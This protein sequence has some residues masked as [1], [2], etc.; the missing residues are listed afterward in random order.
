MP[1]IVVRK[2]QPDVAEAGGAED[3]VSNRMQQHV[4]V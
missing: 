3:R 2:Q 1:L 4:G